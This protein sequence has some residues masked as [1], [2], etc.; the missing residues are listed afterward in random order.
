M[1]KQKMDKKVMTGMRRRNK[2]DIDGSPG[3]KSE[4]VDQQQEL[5]VP[6]IGTMY[7]NSLT[8]VQPLI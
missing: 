3:K 4:S 7:L 2:S 1:R 5:S 6:M 8:Q